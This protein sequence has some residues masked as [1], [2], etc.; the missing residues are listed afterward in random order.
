MSYVYIAPLKDGSAFKIGKSKVPSSRLSGLGRYYDFDVDGIIIINCNT[1]SEAFSTESVLH[2]SCSP[3]RVLLPFDGGTEFF[4]CKVLDSAMIIVNAIC[5]INGYKMTHFIPVG[6]VE[7]STEPELIA[8]SFSCKIKARRLHL[9]I[10]HRELANRAGLSKRTIERIENGET[11][12]F[13]NIVRVV[14]ELGLSDLFSDLHI[15]S[16]VRKRASH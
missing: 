15:D 8:N 10:S 16:G 4:S 5:D 6:N 2:K 3:E 9:N 13:I 7:S 11:A 14:V 12:L 1:D